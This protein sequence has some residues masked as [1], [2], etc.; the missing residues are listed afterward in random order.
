MSN[1]FLRVMAVVMAFV[2]VVAR[3][4]ADAQG[5]A[6]AAA[7]G[8]AAHA[9]TPPKTP[10]GDPD[11][12]GMWLPGGG[13]R[14]E[15]PAGKPWEGRYDPGP[16]SAFSSFFAPTPRPATPAATTTT[17]APRPPAGPMVVDPP[18]GRIPMQPW[19]MDKRTEI[20]ANQEKVEYLD[21]RVRCLQSGVPRANLPVGYNTYQFLQVP[22]AVILLYEWNHMYR[23]IPLD[24]RPH[25][26]PN[27]RLPM[28]DSR[29][30]WEGNTLVV[31]VT[32]FTDTT[33]VVGH[34]APPDNAPASAISTGHG[35]FHSEALHVVERFTL[36]N[37]NT[38]EYEARIEDPK[39]F[40]RPWTIRF[41]AF[42]R[43][44]ADHQ[45][46]EYACHEG[47]GRNVKL[48]TGFDIETG[49][50]GPRPGK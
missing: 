19:A 10:W 25:I 12:Q 3:E 47:N 1:P 45:L 11:L 44:P 34:G 15:T 24:G 40:T 8:K 37:A 22:G 43:A 17:T 48:L 41:N 2:A 9:F 27:I 5:P 6:G 39:V 42:T 38:I 26:S 49:T 33:W 16:N 20:V 35:V 46:F 14:M 30:R 13:G 21:P 7:P 31:D 29:G 36:I 50:Q 23:H 18:D 32:N 4:R 28:G